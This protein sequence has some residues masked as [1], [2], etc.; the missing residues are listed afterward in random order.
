MVCKSQAS[1]FC[2][3]LGS[4]IGDDDNYTTQNLGHRTDII[5]INFAQKNCNSAREAFL[6]LDND[7]DKQDITTPQ[8][9]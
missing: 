8:T 5:S 9:A 4:Y 1:N 3:L 6:S 2:C 7:E